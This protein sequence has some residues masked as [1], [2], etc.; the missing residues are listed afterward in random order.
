MMK[1]DPVF[2]MFITVM[3]ILFIILFLMKINEKKDDE[4]SIADIELY[5]KLNM[6]KYNNKLDCK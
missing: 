1:V 4:L 3:A 6:V 5:K 2:I